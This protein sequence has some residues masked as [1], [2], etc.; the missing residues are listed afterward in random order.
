MIPD[1]FFQPKQAMEDD[2]AVTHKLQKMQYKS[3]SQIP[4]EKI[5]LAKKAKC[6]RKTKR[7]HEYIIIL[8][9]S[10]TSFFSIFFCNMFVPGNTNILM[11]F[12]SCLFDSS[13]SSNP[14]TLAQVCRCSDIAGMINFSTLKVERTWMEDVKTIGLIINGIYKP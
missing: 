7:K 1:P 9:P 8:L 10:C 12:I 2:F 3:K 6:Y 4:I 11:D 14:K 5:F 13:S